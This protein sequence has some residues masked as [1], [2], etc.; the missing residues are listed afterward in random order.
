M[1][2]KNSI[3]SYESKNG[4]NVFNFRRGSTPIS[5]I[6]IFLLRLY[7]LAAEKKFQSGREVAE[8]Y[9]SYAR[10]GGENLIGL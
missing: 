3:F 8:F 1:F 5:R 9:D 2:N 10:N 6:K 4:K 7:A